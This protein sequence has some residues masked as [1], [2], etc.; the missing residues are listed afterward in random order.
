MWQHIRHVASI[1][2]VHTARQDCTHN[3]TG[4][5]HV[6]HPMSATEP[7]TCSHVI[8]ALM[9]M[10]EHTSFKK[11]CCRHLSHCPHCLPQDSQGLCVR[12]QRT[13]RSTAVQSQ[14]TRQYSTCNQYQCSQQNNGQACGALCMMG[15]AQTASTKMRQQS[16]TDDRTGGLTSALRPCASCV[17][18][19]SMQLSDQPHL[20]HFIKRVHHTLTC[21]VPVALVRQQHQPACRTMTLQCLRMQRW[22][23]TCSSVAHQA[24]RPDV[25]RDMHSSA[26]AEMKGIG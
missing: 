18:A 3:A 6:T 13:A 10:S 21:A 26:D 15:K 14:R 20:V 19:V 11:K 7:S 1:N 4:L 23:S 12:S 22:V 2:I 17:H 24:G 16:H 25:P 9:L 8:K 5:R